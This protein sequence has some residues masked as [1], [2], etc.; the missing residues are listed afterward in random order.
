MHNS[1][2]TMDVAEMNAELLECARYGESEDL[3]TLLRQEGVNVDY[4]DEFSRNT[5][6]M[7]IC[8]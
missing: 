8:Y 3:N 4:V 7:W 6:I 1:S 5:G 2:L